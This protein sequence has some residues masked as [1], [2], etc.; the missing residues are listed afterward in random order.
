MGPTTKAFFLLLTLAGSVACESN[1]ERAIRQFLAESCRRD[2][3]AGSPGAS[4]NCPGHPDYELIR[5]K[6]VITCE[7]GERWGS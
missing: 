2:A 1:C 3:I 4:K 6:G 7:S 5:L